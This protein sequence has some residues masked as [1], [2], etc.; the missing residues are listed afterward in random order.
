M[1]AITT[2]SDTLTRMN[3]YNRGSYL[4]GSKHLPESA[5]LFVFN[6]VRDHDNCNQGAAGDNKCRSGQQC[7]VLSTANDSIRG[8]VSMTI[9]LPCKL[10]MV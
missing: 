3:F 9:T 5:L 8:S 10:P 4:Q 2:R 1:E 7:K 6:M